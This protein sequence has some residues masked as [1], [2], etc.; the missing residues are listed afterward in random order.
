MKKASKVGW[1][2]K[3]KDGMVLSG[4]VKIG[5]EL[6]RQIIYECG[7]QE[8]I[9]YI[10]IL[11]H[12]N[13]KTNKCYPSIQKLAD[14]C[15]VSTRT[16]DRMIKKLYEKGFLIIDSGKQGISNTYYF[17]KEEFYN[18]EGVCATRTKKGNFDVKENTKK[19]EENR[20]KLREAVKVINIPSKENTP[21]GV[22]A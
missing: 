7:M 15:K 8:A 10:I 20:K 14:E 22:S 12:R 4:F 5:N 13:T 19:K 2:E 17:P 18:N 11:S 21:F 9:C 3:N 1:S 16:I 6:I